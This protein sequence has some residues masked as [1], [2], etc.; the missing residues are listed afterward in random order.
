MPAKPGGRR[1]SGPIMTFTRNLKH[2]MTG[3]VTILSQSVC[4]TAADGRRSGD[5]AT[6]ERPFFSFRRKKRNKRKPWTVGAERAPRPN[7][8]AESMPYDKGAPA[9]LSSIPF[10]RLWFSLV[11][12]FFKKKEREKHNKG[13]PAVLGSI[14]FD[15][16]WFLWFFHFSKRKNGKRVKKERK[17]RRTPQRRWPPRRRRSDARRRPR[18][19]PDAPR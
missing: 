2:M 1:G 16:L 12:S 14:P 11:P 10:D 13:A 17:A 5:R 8:F 7:S 19:T 3:A 15:R 18:T 4:A 6:I 9:V